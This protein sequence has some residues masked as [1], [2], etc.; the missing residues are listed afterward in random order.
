[1]KVVVVSREGEDYSRAV[2]DWLTDFRRR[3][4]RELTVI[5]PDSPSGAGFSSTYDV[6]E[7]PSIVALAEDGQV[8][9]MWRGLPL[10]TI[11][12]VNY[13]AMGQ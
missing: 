3:T 1:M 4:G 7:Y 5:S 11:D 12:E 2:S 10:P 13:Y 6:V 9:R 8:L